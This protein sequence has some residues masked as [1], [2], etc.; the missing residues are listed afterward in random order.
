MPGVDATLDTVV[1]AGVVE[2]PLSIAVVSATT[3]RS[4]GSAPE[5]VVV[6]IVVVVA[7]LVA[8]LTEVVVDGCA[9]VPV[10]EETCATTID[11]VAVGRPWTD[12][13]PGT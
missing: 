2:F 1:T 7:T 3:W 13:V 4:G 11:V 9:A 6:W 12:K 8:G 10:F 5:M